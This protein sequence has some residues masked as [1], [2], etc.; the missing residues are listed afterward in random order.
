MKLGGHVDYSLLIPNIPSFLFSP[1]W[2]AFYGLITDGS[3]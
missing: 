1:Y 2:F 3:H